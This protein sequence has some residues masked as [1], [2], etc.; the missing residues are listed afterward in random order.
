MQKVIV[1]PT[2]LHSNITLLEN[3]VTLEKAFFVCLCLLQELVFDTQCDKRP[4]VIL[5]KITRFI[6]YVRFDAALFIIDASPIFLQVAFRRPSPNYQKAI[7]VHIFICICLEQHYL[8]KYSLHANLLQYG[9]IVFSQFAVYLSVHLPKI[10][11]SKYQ[12][13]YSFLLYG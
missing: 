6:E 10:R 13:S 3:I 4:Q 2:L 1:A 11:M 7:W 9:I 12:A 5:V 8:A